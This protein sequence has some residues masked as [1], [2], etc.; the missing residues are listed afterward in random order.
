MGNSCGLEFNVAHMDF[1]KPALLNITNFVDRVLS[2]LV[3]NFHPNMQM[4]KPTLLFHI[5]NYSGPLQIY[6]QKNSVGNWE[7]VWLTLTRQNNVLH[8]GF[9]VLNPKYDMDA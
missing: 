1:I 4:T 6:N 9:R 3:F 2:C 5:G 7:L 8:T